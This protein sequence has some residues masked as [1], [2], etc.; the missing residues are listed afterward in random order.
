MA[1]VMLGKD[2]ESPSGG[3]PTIYLDDEKDTYLVQ[4]W[5]VEETERLK[6]MDIPGHESVVEI[7][8]RMVQFFME[9]SQETKDADPEVKKDDADPDV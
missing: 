5:K 4:G 6:V 9:L 7:P 2:P 1:L 3:S 8:R